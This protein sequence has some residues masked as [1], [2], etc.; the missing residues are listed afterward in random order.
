M[1]LQKDFDEAAEHVRRLK[2]TPAD[3]DLLELYALF[4]Q[5]TIGDVDTECP[6]T[7]DSNEITK[8]NAWNHKRGTDCEKAKQDYVNKVRELVGKVGLI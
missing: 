8:W 7:L 2:L 3:G 5:A 4:K 1:D 6:G